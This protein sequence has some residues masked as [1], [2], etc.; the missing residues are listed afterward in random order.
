MRKPRNRFELKLYR[1]LTKAQVPFKY[2][3][4]RIPYLLAGHYLPDYVLSTPNG[5]VY[6]EA[7]GYFRP[8]AKRKLKAVK[9]LNPHL[10]IRLVFYVYKEDNERWAIKNG[11][12]YAFEKIPQTW[13]EG[14]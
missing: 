12:R 13:L 7:K 3:S 4:E 1:Q 9:K 11:F 5:K 2:E 10:D 14:L 6:I 8:E